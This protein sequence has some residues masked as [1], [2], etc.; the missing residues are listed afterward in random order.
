MKQ[1]T[2][3]FIPD[4]VAMTETSGWKSGLVYIHNVTFHTYATSILVWDVV[5]DKIWVHAMV[6]D[7]S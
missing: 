4:A 3:I 6:N 5:S 7:N 2:L 1:K